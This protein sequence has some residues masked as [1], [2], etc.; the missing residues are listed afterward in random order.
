MT[1]RVSASV[2]AYAVLLPASFLRHDL[3]SSLHCAAVPSACAAFVA[4]GHAVFGTSRDGD[5]IGL[6][7]LGATPIGPFQLG[8]KAS[9]LHALKV[10]QAGIVFL[11]TL[12]IDA[13]E[14]AQGA[15][16]LAACKESNVGH[17]IYCSVSHCD[18]CPADVT[19]LSAKFEI[20]KL[21]AKENLRALT[22][23][24][25]VSYFEN[26]H[27]A[28]SQNPLKKGYLKNLH[29]PKKRLPW[30]STVDVARAA[31]AVASDDTRWNGK[32]IECSAWNGSSMELSDALSVAS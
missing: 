31:V 23:L 25:P 9:M 3:C 13:N 11:N 7:G 30:V 26:V 29:D 1:W 20:E 6:T 21:A 2:V 17:V 12:P 24:R 16:M 5:H 32:T 27:D 15:A 4:A 22:I 14:V 18:I 28:A 19:I 8:D 10:S